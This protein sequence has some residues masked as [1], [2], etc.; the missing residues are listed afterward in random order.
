MKLRTLKEKDAQ[1]MLE[2]MKDPEVNQNF[3]FSAN[4]VDMQKIIGFIR[5]AESEPVEGKSIHYAIAGEDDEYLGTISL[6]AVDLSAKKAEYAIS[7][8]KSAQGKGI[9]FRATE[10]L[11]R[12]AFE[13]F[14]FNRVYLNVLSANEKAI[15]LYEKCGF[16]YEGEFR[17]HLYLKGEYASLKWY[18]MLREDYI[19]KKMRN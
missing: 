18:G 2:W 9:G 13:Q 15:C 3:R 6:K 17:Q 11:L 5:E 10:E 12:M 14:G 19:K 16:K 8:R 1:G 4:D 7:L